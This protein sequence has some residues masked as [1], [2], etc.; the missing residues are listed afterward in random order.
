MRRSDVDATLRS[1]HRKRTRKYPLTGPLV[2]YDHQ[3]TFRLVNAAGLPN[4]H[5]QRSLDVNL[6]PTDGACGGACAAGCTARPLPGQ[7]KPAPKEQAGLEAGAK[8][9]KFNLKDQD[10]KERSIGP[11]PQQG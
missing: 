10:G 7:G 1:I 2:Q 5:F 4:P 11:I 3:T 9:P 8:A 6:D